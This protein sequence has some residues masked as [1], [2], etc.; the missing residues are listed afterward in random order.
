MV[1]SGISVWQ[2]WVTGRLT[3]PF[4]QVTAVHSASRRCL[5][6]HAQCDG[7]AFRGAHQPTLQTMIA[8][9]ATPA[10]ISL[11][12]YPRRALLRRTA[13]LVGAAHSN[14]LPKARTGPAAVLQH[15]QRLQV[16]HPPSARVEPISMD[17]GRACKRLARHRPDLGLGS[18]KRSRILKNLR[19]VSGRG[20]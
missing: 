3:P 17:G 18:M 1:E 11:T 19:S 10:G 7:D 2:W 13:N 6:R 15:S 20:A 8:A 14:G 9:M 5:K 4:R 16:Q 12:R